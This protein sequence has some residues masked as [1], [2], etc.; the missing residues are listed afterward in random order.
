MSFHD[1]VRNM[2]AEAK[3][4]Y[5]LYETGFQEQM[6][7]EV[8]KKIKMGE[9]NPIDIDDKFIEN[10]IESNAFVETTKY[11]IEIVNSAQSRWSGGHS[12]SNLVEQIKREVASRYLSNRMYPLDIERKVKHYLGKMIEEELLKSTK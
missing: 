10:M 6:A 11:A 8:M 12:V 3:K 2:E 1:I 7:G 9:V 4:I 5:A